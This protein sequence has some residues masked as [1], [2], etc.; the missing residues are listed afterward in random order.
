[1]GKVG[2]RAARH[3]GA[4]GHGLLLGGLKPVAA[5]LAGLPVLVVVT[6]YAGAISPALAVTVLGGRWLAGLTRRL[7]GRWG[8][9][10]IPAPYLPRPALQRVAHGWYWTGYDY[11]HSRWVARVSLMFNWLVRDPATWRD[12]LWLATDPLIGG[13][14][15]LLPAGL[16]AYGLAMPWTGTTVPFIA[17]MPAGVAAAGVPA[18]PAGVSVLSAGTAGLPGVSVGGAALYGVPSGGAGSPGVSVGGA[19]LFGVPAAAVGVVTVLLG[20]VIALLGVAIAPSLLR[21]H[22]RWTHAVLAPTRQAW[23]ARRVER[24]TETR[25]DAVNAQAAELRRIERDLHDGAQARLVAMGMTL[26]AAEQL[27]RSDPD[28][29]AALVAEVRESSAK[30]LGELRDLVHGIYPPVLAER[31]LGD[32]LRLLALEAPLRV[33]VEVDMAGRPE[34]PLESAAYFAVSELLTNAARHSGATH[35]ELTVRHDGERLRI[36]VA[37]DGRGGADPACGGGLQGVRRRL[38]V[39]DG[40]VTVDSPRGGPTRVMMEIPCALSSPRTSTS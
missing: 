21:M 20:V 16:V 23:L 22:G 31:G 12:L 36:A 7:N 27:I 30:A 15:A 38:G 11:H 26:G 8:G 29:A 1:M 17:A 25:T 40:N 13:L 35:V 37:D 10:E 3:L 34:P 2:A 32:A 19:A 18:V 14:L 5:M 9:I 24:L 6:G 4:L 39:F 33:S 28:A